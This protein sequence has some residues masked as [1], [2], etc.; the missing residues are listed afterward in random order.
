MITESCH[1]RWDC[2]I[3]WLDWKSD[4]VG[5]LK[6]IHMK[7]SLSFIGSQ[8]QHLAQI[9]KVF[10]FILPQRWKC[11]FWVLICFW[12]CCAVYNY[13]YDPAISIPVSQ[14]KLSL[15]R[16]LN[17][18]KLKSLSQNLMRSSGRSKQLRP[19]RIPHSFSN[20]MLSQGCYTVGNLL[21]CRWQ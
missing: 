6:V 11:E 3:S 10:N 17:D 2:T 21:N 1:C 8:Q 9:D 12:E 16:F 5:M 13:Y 7:S 18:D 4:V 15:I 19:A 14:V 20:K